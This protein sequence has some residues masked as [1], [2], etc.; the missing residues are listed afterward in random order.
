[1]IRRWYAILGIL[2]VLVVGSISTA[3]QAYAAPT[4]TLSTHCYD[5]VRVGPTSGSSGFYGAYG[6]IHA[7]C[8]S[9]SNAPFDFTTDETWLSFPTG[10][11]WVEAGLAYGDPFYGKYFYWA[12]QR[13]GG[14]YHEH[15]DPTDLPDNTTPYYFDISYIGSGNYDVLIGPMSGTSTGWSSPIANRIDTGTEAS[16]GAVSVWGSSSGLGY[17]TLANAAHN[18]WTW[19]GG[20]T[21]SF[22]DPSSWGIVQTVT[23]NRFYRIGTQTTSC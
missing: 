13:P 16:G 15:D 19:S 23:S 14:G 9:N 7:A 18:Y 20:N 6:Y 8:L 3:P 1:M 11:Y 5:L 17:Y 21:Y 2:A 10:N 4:C 12:D 22:Q